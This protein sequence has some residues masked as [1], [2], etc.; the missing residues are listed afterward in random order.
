MRSALRLAER[1]RGRTGTN[2][3]VG[4]VVV[5]SGRIVGGG[6]HAGFGLPH[7]EA[8]ALACARNKSRGA[9]IY[10]TLEPCSRVGKTPPCTRMIIASG[11]RET[12]FAGSDPH[13]RGRGARELS[14][15]GVKVRG[16]LLEQEARVLNREYFARLKSGRPYV[17]LKLAMTADGKIADF[18]GHSKWI[19]SAAA[20]N[21]TRSLRSQVD[22]V[23]VGAGTALADDPRLTSPDRSRQPWKIIVDGKARLPVSA[24][25]LRG[26]RL[27]LACLRGVP[28]SRREA[29]RSSGAEILELPGKRGEVRLRSLMAALLRRGIGSI[30]CEGG[31]RLAGSLL[32]A[33]LVDRVI[34]VM[35]PR[36]LGGS[37]SLPALTGRERPLGKAMVLR[38]VSVRRLGGDMV[39]EGMLAGGK[40]G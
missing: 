33:R 6:W 17:T 3:M 37:R 25:V 28:A 32:E 18:R 10:V 20:R 27:L 7:A 8:V 19:S 35:A 9:T 29:L 15:N 26:G 40:K 5:R 34:L 12:V 14:A 31:S 30:L 38:E 22:A 21:W 16:G 23:M 24:R 39:M 2:P 11:V 4:A 36:L 1:G 13:E